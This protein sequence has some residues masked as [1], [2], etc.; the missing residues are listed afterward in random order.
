MEI[1]NSVLMITGGAIRVGK[2]QALHMARKG[3]YISFSY[4]LR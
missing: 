3:A 4:M 2:A 1:K